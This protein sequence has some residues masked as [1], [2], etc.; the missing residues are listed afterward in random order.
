MHITNEHQDRW[1]NGSAFD[2]RSK[3]YPFKSG[4]VQF[5]NLA[6]LSEVNMLCSFFYSFLVLGGGDVFFASCKQGCL[7]SW[8]LVFGKEDVARLTSTTAPSDE[9]RNSSTPSAAHLPQ[10]RRHHLPRTYRNIVDCQMD[11]RPQ[12]VELRSCPD[13]LRRFFSTTLHDLDTRARS[14]NYKSP[15]SQGTLPSS[16]T[17]LQGCIV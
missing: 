7:R 13:S 15:F 2:S 16:P 12:R 5:P 6:N 10:H 11:S 9:I 17:G 8:C 4:V 3:G 1:R 14:S